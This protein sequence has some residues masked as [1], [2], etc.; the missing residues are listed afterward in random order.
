MGIIFDIQRCSY[1]DGPGIR[2][3]VFLKGCNL[4]CPWCHNPESFLQKPQLQYIAG[5]C[6][7][8][9]RC[10]SMCP[11]QVHSFPNQLHRVDFQKCNVSK[12]CIG[13]CPT[14]A[15]SL[16]G[17]EMSADEILQIILKDKDYYDASQGGVTFSGGEP[18]FQP[19]FL[20]ELLTLSKEHG[21]HTCV[22]TNGY[23]RK[24]ILEQILPL[25]DLFLLD[26]KTE[27]PEALSK[28]PG[29]GDGRLWREA[30][31][32][33]QSMN[34]PVILRLPIIPG[35]NDNPEHFAAAKAVRQRYPVIRKLEVMPYH[36]L[37]LDK[38]S[39]VGLDY[40]LKE[41]PGATPQQTALWNSMLSD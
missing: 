14:G 1:N 37:G 41:Q 20:L 2:T 15:L 27:D 17:Q 30:L 23:V 36:L 11:N 12:A 31:D 18:T 34:K 7:H 39:R 4:R 10:G 22:E 38:W 28:I 8:C 3:T 5:K 16:I 32:Y 35:F 21:L 13:V 40:S 19:E 29:T 6:I 33:I 24:P 9:R 25:T 26:Y